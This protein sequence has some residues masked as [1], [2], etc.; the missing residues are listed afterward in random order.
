MTE[1]W[2]PVVG[3]EGLYEVSNMGRVK[4]LA[5]IVY[6]KRRKTLYERI[7]AP[8][9]F[10]AGYLGVQL[11][12]NCVPKRHSIHRLVM[13]AFNPNPDNKEHI[14]HID[15]N[16]QNNCLSNLRWATNLENQRHSAINRRG[17]KNKAAVLVVHLEYGIFCN[18]REAAEMSCLDQRRVSAML[19]GEESNRTKFIRA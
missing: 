2:L 19:R 7:L 6:G 4:S 9:K 15:Y 17:I 3:Y 16:K 10:P 5:R 8:V 11:C 1:T 14:D 18:I 13:T 12:K